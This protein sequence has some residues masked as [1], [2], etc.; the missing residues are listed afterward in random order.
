MRIVVAPNAMKGS[1][2]AFDFA[3][4]IEC[5]LR[6]AHLN[7]IVKIPVADGGDGTAK[8]LSALSN[9]HF[10]HSLVCDPLNRPIES[11]FYIDN[12]H[13]AFIEMADASGLKLLQK[14]EYSPL[15]STSYGTGQL[16]KH[17]IE[18]GARKII[19]C[20]GGSATVDAGTG[21]L[22]AL[23]TKFYNNKNKLIEQGCG[24]TLDQIDKI[25]SSETTSLLKNIDIEIIADVENLISGANGAAKT[26]APQKGANPNEVIQLENKIKTFVSVLSAHSK[27]HAQNITG[28]GA[29]GGFAATFAAL[30]NIRINHGA[31]Y[32]LRQ[33]GF[34][35][36][37]KK[38]DAIITGEGII[39]ESTLFGKAPGTILNFGELANIPVY[40]ICGSNLLQ[41]PNK[42]EKVFALTAIEKNPQTA[43][44]KA[45][46]LTVIQAKKLGKYI[47]T[48][49]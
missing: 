33:T 21:A 34:F 48:K 26:F 38:A 30:L 9:S 29:A 8:I 2:D 46:E 42:F 19:L 40:A 32:I 18:I 23:G 4:A 12:N 15:H 36:A 25:D 22:M 11:G 20:L 44:N 24:N 3:D 35:E 39:D 41:T 49:Q 7:H 37:T 45:Y 13:T 16:I 10:V 14:N 6:K 5:G 27:T 47:N 1:L 43:M 17:A 28:G 31:N